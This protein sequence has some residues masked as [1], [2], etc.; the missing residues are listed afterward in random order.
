MHHVFTV[1]G[2]AGTRAYFTAA[3]MVIATPRKAKVF[4]E[5]VFFTDLSK[6]Y[7]CYIQPVALF[8]P[9]LRLTGTVLALL[10]VF[11]NCSR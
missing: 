4:L 3:T 6:T 10:V 11:V 2:N 7:T 5:L 8:L 1:E 9:Q